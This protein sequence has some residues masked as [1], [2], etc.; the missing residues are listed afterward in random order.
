M[1]MTQHISNGGTMNLDEEVALWP[2]M[3]PKVYNPNSSRAH[4]V[5][6]PFLESTNRKDLVLVRHLLSQR[7]YKNMELPWDVVAHKLRNEIDPASGKSV[8]DDKNRIGGKDVQSRFH[9]Y[10]AFAKKMVDKQSSD[11]QIKASPGETEILR[12]IRTIY[13]DWE[14][15]D[16]QHLSKLLEEK[17]I[18]VT[19]Y[20]PPFVFEHAKSSVKGKPSLQDEIGST[21]SLKTDLSDST[22]YSE[23]TSGLP[24][25]VIQTGYDTPNR[26]GQS[27]DSSPIS[28]NSIMSIITMDPYL[29]EPAK[30]SDEALRRR[31]NASAQTYNVRQEIKLKKEDSKKRKRVEAEENRALFQRER[32][33]LYMR[34]MEMEERDTEFLMLVAL[35]LCGFMCASMCLKQAK[36]RG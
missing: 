17:K 10:M 3:T 22:T 2:D 5:R 29:Q 36:S 14:T 31:V 1:T 24:L 23:S 33:E 4:R 16:Q 26:P 13:Q 25:E 21:S 35:V 32:L 18:P 20:R 34:I 9:A 30:N 7:P 12:G 28:D 19:N 8:F 27:K 15:M 11:S 6:Y